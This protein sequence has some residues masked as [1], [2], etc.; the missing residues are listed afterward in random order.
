MVKLNKSP[1]PK[2]VYIR[3]EKTVMLSSECENLRNRIIKELNDFRQK[4]DLHEDEPD[5]LVKCGFY[6]S[7]ARMIERSSAFAAFKR[8]IIRRNTAYMCEFGGHLA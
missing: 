4:L 6:Q 1:L 7:I 2:G 5:T 8:G 3:S